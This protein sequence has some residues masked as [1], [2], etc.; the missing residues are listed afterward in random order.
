MKFNRT[1]D[2]RTDPRHW[3][4]P[5]LKG[6]LVEL[7]RE[8]QVR[9]LSKNPKLTELADWVIHDLPAIAPSDPRTPE[10]VGIAQEWWSRERSSK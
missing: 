5:M 10:A 9:P 7:V 4:T 3:S 8:M 6:R 1:R 2:G